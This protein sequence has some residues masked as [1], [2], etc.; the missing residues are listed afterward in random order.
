M[1]RSQHNDRINTFLPYPTNRPNWAT[2]ASNPQLRCKVC[3]QPRAEHEFS[4][5]ST[6]HKGYCMSHAFSP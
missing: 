3:N 1:D 2:I 5:S 6:R 4:T